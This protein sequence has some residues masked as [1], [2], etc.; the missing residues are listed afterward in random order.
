M[1]NVV[2]DT[3]VLVS[4]LISS[5]GNC[6][7]IINAFKDKRFNLFYSAEILSEYS[8]V[9]YR[10]KFGFNADD[11]EDLLDEICLSGVLVSSDVGDIPLPDEDDRVFYDTALASGAI[12]ITGNTKHYPTE[13]FIMTPADFL[14]ECLL[15]M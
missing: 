15:D 8:N 13:P 9:L 1:L 2:L 3:N 4:G 5:N 12:L 7:K 14:I 6:A 10:A 11:I